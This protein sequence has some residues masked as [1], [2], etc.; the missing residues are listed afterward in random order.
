M[1]NY[2]PSNK[3]MYLLYVFRP[4]TTIS[5]DTKEK[6]DNCHKPLDIIDSLEDYFLTFYNELA[7]L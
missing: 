2:Y 3:Y 1:F 4:P 7:E 5:F 6:I